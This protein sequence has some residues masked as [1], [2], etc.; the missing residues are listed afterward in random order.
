MGTAGTTDS[1]T[2]DAQAGFEIMAQILLSTFSGAGLVHDI[3]F[4][5]CADI[6]SLPLLV[7]ADEVIGYTKRIMKGIRVNQETIMMELIEKIGPGGYFVAE[8]ESVKLCRQEVWVPKLSDR[9]P[10]RKWEANGSLSME[11]RATLRAKYI[12]E[13]Y[14]PLDLSPEILEKI[15][16]ILD[17]EERRV[18]S[19]PGHQ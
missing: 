2:L 16:T 6:G 8:P 3:G 13:H 10:Y 17:K 1:K 18:K 14:Q 11:E 12:L 9:K 4:L 7:M 19:S 15:Q 5:D